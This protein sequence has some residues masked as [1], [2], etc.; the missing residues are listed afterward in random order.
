MDRGACKESDMTVTKHKQNAL[1][2]FLFVSLHP[3]L[4]HLSYTF[5][6]HFVYFL[7]LRITC[8]SPDFIH[9]FPTLFRILINYVLLRNSPQK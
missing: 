6:S 5:K 3:N 4:E 7:F 1:F 9:S 8:R 2:N